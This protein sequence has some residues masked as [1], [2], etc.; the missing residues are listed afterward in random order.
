MNK[1]IKKTLKIAGILFLVLSVIQMFVLG[2]RIYA[3][4]TGMLKVT[5][6]WFDYALDAVEI[7]LSLVTG[8]I[9]LLQL[10]KQQEDILKQNKLFFGLCMANILNSFAGW[11]ISFWVQIATEQ[12]KKL[13]FSFVNFA[14]TVTDEANNTIREITDDGNIVVDESGYEVLHTETL[15][16][17][18]EEINRLRNKNLISEEE[19][20]KLRQEA[21]DK[22]LN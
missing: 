6:T 20:T 2:T 18:L 12:A 13:N 10:S 7:A 15:T 4:Q 1:N 8:I 9:Y 5:V 14:E 17:R 11:V 21:I 16:T 22:F 19:Y 3:V